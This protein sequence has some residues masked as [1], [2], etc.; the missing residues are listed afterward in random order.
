M[1]AQPFGQ[2]EG[3]RQPLAVLSREPTPPRRFNGGDQPLRVQPGGQ[4]TPRADQLGSQRS[5]AHADHDALRRRPSAGDGVV[6]HVILHLLVHAIG[7]PAEGELPQGDEVPLSEEV[8]DG[9]FGLPWDIDL[10]LRQALQELVG[11]QIDQRDLVGA[12]QDR[13]GDRLADDH[14][15]DLGHHIIQTFHVLDVEGGIDMD[16]GLEKLGD[17]LPSLRVPGAGRVGMGQLIYQ[18]ERGMSGK[19]AIQVE[20]PEAD[21]SIC[22]HPGRQDL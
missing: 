10:A 6:S 12:V 4:A 19:G 9:L 16:A 11:G 7:G 2:A 22:K 17:I 5:G 14:A 21:P 20:F 3:L 8:V 1:P 13:I 18:E 15:R